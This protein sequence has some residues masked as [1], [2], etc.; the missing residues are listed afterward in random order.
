M[1]Y[2][3]DA[4]AVL[5]TLNTCDAPVPGCTRLT[6]PSG[7]T[8]APGFTTV[9]FHLPVAAGPLGFVGVTVN[10][11]APV[12]EPPVENVTVFITE[13]PAAISPPMKGQSVIAATE[14]VAAQLVEYRVS[15][16]PVFVTVNET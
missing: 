14:P 4:L 1:S 15:M 8:V 10:C 6:P 2:V 13:L 12:P 7:V 11:T 9:S 5:V 3:N 16:V